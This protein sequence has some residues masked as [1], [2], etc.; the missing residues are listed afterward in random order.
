MAIREI[1]NIVIKRV[2]NPLLQIEFLFRYSPLGRRFYK[3]INYT[4]NTTREVRIKD[5]FVNIRYF[6]GY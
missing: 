1:S 4:H 3:A 2:E 5:C 6:I